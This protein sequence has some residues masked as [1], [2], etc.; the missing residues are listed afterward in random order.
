MD[1][2]QEQDAIICNKVTG[3]KLSLFYKIGFIKYNTKNYLQ[4]RTTTPR[5]AREEKIFKMRYIFIPIHQGMHYTCAVIYMG[6]KK[7]KYYNS[8]LIDNVTRQSCRHKK[9]YKRLHFKF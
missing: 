4:C 1:Y 2:L 7:I 3:R 5:C 9:K 6:E 8:L